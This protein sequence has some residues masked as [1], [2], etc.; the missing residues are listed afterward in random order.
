[1]SRSVDIPVR[2]DNDQFVA[3]LQESITAQS[4]FR[5]CEEIELAISY[6]QYESVSIEIDSLGGDTSYLEYYFLKLQN[7]QGAGVTVKTT[8]LTVAASASAYILACGSVGYRGSYPAARIVFHYG[9]SSSRSNQHMTRD[10]LER[11]AKRLAEVD[12]QFEMFL[13]DNVLDAIRLNSHTQY[14][15]IPVGADRDTVLSLNETWKE[16]GI[17]QKDVSSRRTSELLQVVRHTVSEV[18]K[19]GREMSPIVAQSLL[20]I[21]NVS[22]ISK[23]D[24]EGK[25]NA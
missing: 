25:R 24:H 11:R 3:R 16:L 5:L 2:Y 10:D 15:I 8:A 18:H 13:V 23:R 4:I 17:S 7:W 19:A 20:F 9:S 21:D 6:Y 12:S 22:S 14:P 1:M